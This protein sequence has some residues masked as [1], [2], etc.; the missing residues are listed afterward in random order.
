MSRV[1]KVRAEM[2]RRQLDAFISLRPENRSYLTGFTGTAGMAVVTAT[3]AYL[4]TDFRYV[5]QAQAQAPGFAVRQVGRSN[6]YAEELKKILQEEGIRRVG[7][8][9]DY[10]TVDAHNRYAGELAGVDLVPAAGLVEGIRR[11][12]EPEE[13]EAIRRAAALAD[14]AFDHIL[15]FLRAGVTEREVALELEFFMRR[16]GASALAFDTIVASGP[17]SSLPHGVASD[18]AIGRGDLVT[19]DFGCVVDGYCSDMTRTVAVGEPDE[20][21]REIYAIVLEAQERGLVAVRAGVAARDVDAACRDFIAARGYG[22][23]FGHS[24]GHG[25]GRA[26]HEEPRL[27]AEVDDVLVPGNVV[28][29]EPGIYLPGWGGVRIEDLVL[30]TETGCEILSRSPKALIVLE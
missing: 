27:A 1:E 15:R 10:L 28:T 3:G 19:L 16:R 26:V 9:S 21:Q 4:L 24:T 25:V 6:R 20:K 13:I 5:E 18:R 7:F 8:E 30:V 17:R 29:V 23:N 12:K 2:Q 11:V 22:E 14:E